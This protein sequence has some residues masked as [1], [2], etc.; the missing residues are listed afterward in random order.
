MAIFAT[1]FSRLC[2]WRSCLVLVRPKTVIRWHRAGWKLFWRYKCR[3]GR[4]AIS[5]EIRQL[6]QRMA[7]ENSLWGEERIA[8]ELLVKLDIRVSA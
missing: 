6:I 3:Q 2:D 8:N 1:L 5:L 7:R 4:P